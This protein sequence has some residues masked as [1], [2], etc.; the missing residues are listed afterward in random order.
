MIQAQVGNLLMLHAGALCD[1][2]SGASVVFVAPGGT[3]KT[4]L[5]RTLGVRFG[6]LTGETVG[7]DRNGRVHPYPKPLSIRTG[8]S[9]SHKREVSPDDLG[10][11]YAHPDPYVARVVLLSRSNDHEAMDVE[12]MRCPTRSSPWRPRRPH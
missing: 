6:Y 11:G 4:T 3:G 9:M 5:A 12:E 7:I 1:L 8:A 2:G 10:L